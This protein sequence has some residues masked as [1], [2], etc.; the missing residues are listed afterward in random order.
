[1]TADGDGHDKGPEHHDSHGP[2]VPPPPPA[3][4]GFPG[5]FGHFA[6]PP[7]PKPGV[8]PLRPLDLGDIFGGLFATVRQ[9]WRPL[10]ALT[11]AV[12]GGAF[13]ICAAAAAAG[14][15]A[16]WGALDD[17]FSAAGDPSAALDGRG[18]QLIVA[19]TVVGVV[20]LVVILCAT[21]AL[22]SV[23]TVVVSRAVTGAPATAGDVWREAR[24]H[25]NSVLGTQL[26]VGL[27]LAA[28]I[29]VGYA[30]A[31]GIFAVSLAGA[32][33]GGG[34]GAAGVIGFLFALLLA[35][36]SICAVVF[37]SV[38][39]SFAPASAVLEQCSGRTAMGRSWRLV[40]GS[41]WRVCG[42]TLLVGI[43]VATVGQVLQYAVLLIGALGMAVLQPNA[44][45]IG[46]VGAALG[47][48]ALMGVSLLLSL[49]TE[50]FARLTLALLYVDVRIRREGLDLA[51]ATAAGLPP[52]R[53]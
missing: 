23:C 24:P 2:G 52:H 40:Q 16:V 39:F 9:Y 31:I 30:A 5:P 18:P 6:P 27:L 11:L 17:V 22:H 20:W 10:Y 37:F 4:A 32:M 21:A 43:V 25:L 44:Q 8:I 28:L 48:G 14:A 41:W 47:V 7:A 45:E 15:A 42:I 29:I 38:R 50:P 35:L 12:L 53:P 36:A 33:N 51:L 49:L 1:M 46:P 3:P 13:L 26:R 19:G 34:P